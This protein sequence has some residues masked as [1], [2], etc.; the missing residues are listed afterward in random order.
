MD[1]QRNVP[2][3]ILVVDDDAP[4][5]EMLGIVLRQEGFDSQACGRGDVDCRLPP[6]LPGPSAATRP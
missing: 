4:L 2:K 5:A 6:R 3:N 1:G